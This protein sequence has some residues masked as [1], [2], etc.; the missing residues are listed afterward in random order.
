MKVSPFVGKIQ[1]ESFTQ[2][3]S[4]FLMSWT[5]NQSCWCSLSRTPPSHWCRVWRT[6]G[7]SIPAYLCWPQLRGPCALLWSSQIAEKEAG[8]VR[9][10]CSSEV[11]LS[12]QEKMWC[13][14]A[15]SLMFTSASSNTVW[16]NGSL[17]REKST[18]SGW[19]GS[20]ELWLQ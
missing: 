11:G 20:R 5:L 10:F 8:A 7:P 13:C 16:S 19:D 6:R 9:T 1:A 12:I 17:L 4:C 18:G 3:D 2:A 15:S 14:I